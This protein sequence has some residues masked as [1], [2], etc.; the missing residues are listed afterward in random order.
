MRA[1]EESPA[2]A[3]VVAADE[4]MRIL[5]RGLLQLHRVRVDGEAEGMTEALRVL[6][7]HRPSLVVADT[8][9]SDGTA[10]EL[11]TGARAQL[12]AVRF[13]LIAPASRPPQ[14]F[15]LGSAP[16]V[17]LLKP[18]RIQQF[19]EAIAPPAGPASAG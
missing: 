15:P 6:R 16:D 12:P 9:L 18:F 7:D 8:H 5:L 2:A 17:V 14:S 10:P 3:V 13:V 4:E 1:T 11:V 19:A